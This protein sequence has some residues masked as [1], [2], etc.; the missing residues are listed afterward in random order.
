MKK[1]EIKLLIVLSLLF[2]G[3]SSKV[4]SIIEVGME[5]KKADKILMNFGAQETQ[6]QI[7]PKK[8]ITGEYM[9]LKIYALLEKPYVVINHEEENGI[10][11]IKTM[12]LYY[13]RPDSKKNSQGRKWEDVVKIDLNKLEIPDYEY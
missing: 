5:F 7:K 1:N 13:I 6:L 11:I 4:E 8:S 10:S 9:K 12:S 3:C 2:N